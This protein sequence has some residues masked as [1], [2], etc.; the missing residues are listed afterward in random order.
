MCRSTHTCTW[1]HIQYS[2]CRVA[3]SWCPMRQT[4]SGSQ[5][6]ILSNPPPVSMETEF[7]GLWEVKSWVC[8]WAN[9]HARTH[10]RSLED[11]QVHLEKRQHDCRVY[12]A[13]M[14]V[15]AGLVLSPRG[16]GEH[17]RKEHIFH[18]VSIKQEPT[19]CVMYSH[20]GVC[21]VCVT[22]TAGM[23]CHLCWGGKLKWFLHK[24]F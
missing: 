16:E 5:H 7:A 9:E 8:T 20:R 11:E 18:W 3:D 12:V 13:F 19:G 22:T 15:M 14:W 2:T 4:V 17:W 21:G 6:R 24:I 10:A 1:I 23:K